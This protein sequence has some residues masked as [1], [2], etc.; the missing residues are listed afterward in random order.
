MKNIHTRL[1]DQRDSDAGISLVE[2]IVAMMV[3]AIISLG[4]AYSLGTMMT[5]VRDA[6]AREVATNLAAQEIDV[7]RAT[8]NLTTL[9]D[10][11]RPVTTVNGVPFT[12]QR[13]TRWITD[14]AAGGACGIVGGA[15]TTGELQYKRVAVTVTW[16]SSGGGT[17]SAS[18]ETLITPKARVSGATLGTIIVSVRKEAGAGQPGIG[19]TVSPAVTPAPGVTDAEGCIYITKVAPGPYTVTVNA[20]G[21]VDPDQK[22]NPNRVITVGAGKSGG[23]SFSI[24]KAQPLQLDYGTVA[25]PKDFDTSLVHASDPVYSSIAPTTAL[26]RTV[27]LYPFREGY[28]ALGGK[29]VAANE[30]TPGCLS[31]HPGMWPA[32]DRAG[33]YVAAKALVP[34]TPAPTVSTTVPMGVVTFAKNKTGTAI[35]AESQPAPAG[36]GDP[37]CAA[38]TMKYKFDVADATAPS[39]S[40]ALPFG[41]WKL[42]YGSSPDPA[43]VITTGLVASTVTGSVVTLDPRVPSTPPVP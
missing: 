13:T 17:R 10:V 30:G 41:S 40:L 14:A 34:V 6:R 1:R 20:P 12:V 16:P 7:A 24:E 23:A 11:V 32:G 42:Y 37:G 27:S 22:V 8:A 35:Y 43:Q 25:I 28:L 2:V 4:L 31:P 38:L 3:F 29:Y 26:T 19:I 9:L 21:Y 15:S 33:V 36:S 18:S 39:L 5:Q